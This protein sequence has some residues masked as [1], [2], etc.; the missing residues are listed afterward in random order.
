LIIDRDG[1]LAMLANRWIPDAV[2]YAVLLDA[3]A[4]GFRADVVEADR[5]E[6]PYQSWLAIG[7]RDV[8][9]TG[10]V[11][12]SL[13]SATPDW[14]AGTAMLATLRVFSRDGDARAVTEDAGASALQLPLVKPSGS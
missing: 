5:P 4:N 1:T 14:P 7:P 8:G 6:L 9:G 13:E 10:A 11:I 3:G 12:L 2:P